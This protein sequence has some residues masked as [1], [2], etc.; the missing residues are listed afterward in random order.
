MKMMSRSVVNNEFEINNLVLKNR[1]FYRF[2][3]LFFFSLELRRQA[4]L[5]AVADCLGRLNV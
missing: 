4:R 3:P 1:S 2:F 5:G